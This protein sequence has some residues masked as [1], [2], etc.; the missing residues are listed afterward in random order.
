ML[1]HTIPKSAPPMELRRYL[2]RAYPLLNARDA[3]KKRDVKVNGAR[4][5]GDFTV[6]PGDVIRVYAP[7]DTSIAIA[8]RANGLLAVVKPQGLPVDVDA[9]GIGEDT[10]LARARRI[11]PEARLCHRL[12]AQTGGVLLLAE[13]DSALERALTEFKE[14]RVRKRY[15]AV[16]RGGFDR[17]EGVYRDH[18]RK[19]PGKALVRITP[20]GKGALTVE[21]RWKMA[22]PLRGGLT[23]VEL[24][25]VTGRT[26]QLRVHMAHY[27][28]P[29]LGDD[30]YGD[31]ALNRRMGTK[32]CLWCEEL[33]LGEDVF[34]AEAPHWLE[35]DQN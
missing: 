14:H 24:E 11:A 19:D 35:D 23:R 30:K 2:A 22:R 32:L 25:P 6:G 9:Q 5:D 31:R 15:A 21:T 27:G 13:E 28:H 12:D 7:L 10:A 20:P 34:R 16:V 4:R 33:R 29:I 17:P 18:L 3:L 1:E 8:G 26:H